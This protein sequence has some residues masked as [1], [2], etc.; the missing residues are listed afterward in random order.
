M[1]PI[2]GWGTGL[3]MNLVWIFGS[4][5]PVLV[6][7]ATFIFLVLIFGGLFQLG[8]IK[9]RSSAIIGAIFALLLAIYLILALSGVF[10]S[11]PD[12]AL[13]PL[14]FVT[15]NVGPLPLHVAIGNY[16]LGVFVLLAG[17]VLGLVGGILPRD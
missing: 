4:G 11:I 5:P 1:Y 15:N 9:S 12:I 2:Y 13:L 7:I 6:W 16:G 17:G 10:A 14:L 8:G 3:L